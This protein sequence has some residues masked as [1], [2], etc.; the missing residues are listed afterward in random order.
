MSPQQYVPGRG[1]V[2]VPPTRAIFQWMMSRTLGIDNHSPGGRWLTNTPQNAMALVTIWSWK[3]NLYAVTMAY[4]EDAMLLLVDTGI[5]EVQEEKFH[6]L[7]DAQM[8]GELL[9][10]RAAGFQTAQEMGD[11]R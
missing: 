11:A 7:R 8:H 2:E 1:V 10:A 9:L 6:L 3:P 5:G 4:G